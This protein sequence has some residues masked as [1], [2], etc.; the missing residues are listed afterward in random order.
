MRN[1]INLHTIRDDSL[2]GT[3]KFVSKTEDSQKYG[4]LIPDGMIN[5]DIKDSKAYKTYYDFATGK[6]APKK[7]RK[8]KKIASPLR[9]LSPIKE[10]K[11]VKKDKRVKRPTKKSTTASTADVVINDTPGMSVS[12]KKVATKAD[13]GKGI[14]LLSDAAL[15]E[16]AQLKKALEKIMQE[17]HKLQASGS[18]EGADFESKVLDE[19]KAKPSGIDEG[20]SIKPGVPDVPTYESKSENESWGDSQDDESNDDDDDNDGV[21][22]DGDNKDNDGDS[23]AHDSE[24]TDLD[25]D[26]EVNPNL[27]LKDDEEE[28]TQDDEYIHT[29]DYYVPTDEES[30]KTNDGLEDV[31][32]EK[33]YEQVVKDAHATLT[34]SHK[35]YGSK[36][37]SSVSFD[38][39]SKIL[40]LD[41]V[42][43]TDSDIA[44]LINVK[45]HQDDSSTHAPPLL[46]VPVTVIL[47]TSIV[48]ST[49]VP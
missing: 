24:R 3:L 44:S 6:V 11:P 40:N 22:K 4:A 1:M 23:D 34:S 39:A 8:F 31:S 19:S 21:N 15:L 20:T 37:S 36:Q 14:E 41:N 35:T 48:S 28:E 29:P 42:P 12:K 25:S 32:Q 16:D 30:Q 38:F 7:A 2:L 45:T 26:E 9:K 17:T 49:T 5:Q 43:L 33:T 46:I 47:E 13:R 18:S 10:A 27:N